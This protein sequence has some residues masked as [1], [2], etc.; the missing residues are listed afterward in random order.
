MGKLV[1][2][3]YAKSFFRVKK[4]STGKIKSK[5]TISVYHNDAGGERIGIAM[6]VV[7]KGEVVANITYNNR[8]FVLNP[9]DNDYISVQS[10]VSEGTVRHPKVII[11]ESVSLAGT[12]EP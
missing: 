12:I 7:K 4:I 10:I 8:K 3:V 11:V 5:K 1:R 6:L 2:V 9:E